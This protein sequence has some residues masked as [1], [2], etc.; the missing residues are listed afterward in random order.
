MDAQGNCVERP[1]VRNN[2]Q[3]FHVDKTECILFTCIENLEPAFDF[4]IYMSLYCLNHELR[5]IASDNNLG[6]TI[7][8]NVECRREYAPLIHHLLYWPECQTLY[9][10][11]QI[12]HLAHSP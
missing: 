6:S 2:W 11:H 1:Q 4:I 7:F 5:N 9:V 12:P 3:A 10:E 8:I